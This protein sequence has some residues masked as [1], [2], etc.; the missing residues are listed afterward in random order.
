MFE[1]TKIK[2]ILS[3]FSSSDEN[4]QKEMINQLESYGDLAVPLVVESLRF[5]KLLYAEA[6]R[7]FEKLFSRERLKIFVD[8]LGDP[9]DNIRQ[10]YKNTIL[11]CGKA[12]VA[13]LLV[14]YLA[15]DDHMIRIL[16]GE[17]I[18]EL[19]VGSL[20]GRV[21]PFVKH[22]NR[23]V[24]KVAMDV[25][26]SLKSSE[27]SAA[28]LPLLD[29]ND[30]WIRRKA[31]ESICKL[32]DKST[33]P[34]LCEVLDNE[35]DPTI[36][37]SII[38]ALG[39]IGDPEDAERILPHLKN[40]DMI[41]RQQATDT[42]INIADSTLVPRLME[43]FSEKDVN[44]RRAAVEVLNGL[45]DPRSAAVLVKALKDGDWWVREIATDA[46]SEL[47][48]SK[49]SKLI[50]DLLEDEDEGVRRSAVEFFCRVK[51]PDAFE[52]LVKMLDD[53]DWW[54]R[55]KAITALGLIGDSRGAAEI[56]KLVTDP[57]VVWAIPKALAQI[58]GEEAMEPLSILAK[59]PQ[60]QV[61]IEA[62]KAI[63]SLDTKDSVDAVKLMVKDSDEGVQSLA[64]K[65]LKN[66]TGRIWLLDEVLEDLEKN[67]VAKESAKPRNHEIKP[68]DFLTEGI[69][70]VDICHSTDIA[71]TYGDNLALEL[72]GDLFEIIKP[73][74]QQEGAQ[75]IKS[76]GDGFL[77][78]FSSVLNAVNVALD[79]L[80]Q[81]Q[82]RNAA[83]DD[84]HT[85]ELRF[86]INIGETRV[87]K[88][89]DRVG[90]AVNMAFRV[91]SVQKD[92]MIPAPDG[93]DP[94]SMPEKNRIF[95][96]EPAYHELQKNSDIQTRLLGFFELKGVTGLHRVYEL[97]T[98]F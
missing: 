11:K 90:L 49:I 68:G 98:P 19:G 42:I 17:L 40:Q 35:K 9:K 64:L 76:T 84:K 59:N 45:K 67:S 55:E 52:H 96:T 12:A 20:T 13:P 18:G 57:E 56:G 82:M 6:G 41:I 85:I 69:L 97:I 28:I 4:K 44:I 74:S 26:C 43:F 50:I 51:D 39:E 65:L 10:L 61:R 32:K 22:P 88:S 66:I 93:I 37:R 23:E 8:G 77:I 58:G 62:L 3:R 16:T 71:N 38:K 81:V 7:I 53:T 73:V 1:A 2:R 70:V 36:L 48:G 25:L 75:F 89:G 92:Q 78:T 15:H 14:E 27:A 91:E 47:G 63:A 87:D 5:N 83:V 31:V 54:V 24:K 86:A 60:K 46:L 79:V 29:E 72:S 30:S 33:I 94:D 34:K 95:I 21:I 80:E